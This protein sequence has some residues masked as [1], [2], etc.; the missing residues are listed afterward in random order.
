MKKVCRK[1]QPFPVSRPKSTTQGQGSSHIRAGAYRI[2]GGWV[3]FDGFD[4][5]TLGGQWQR[6]RTYVP[7]VAIWRI[8]YTTIG[9][10]Y[11]SGA[12]VQGLRCYSPQSSV[13]VFDACRYVSGPASGRA[14]SDRLSFGT[15]KDVYLHRLESRNAPISSSPERRRNRST[16]KLN[17]TQSKA[18]RKWR[19]NVCSM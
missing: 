17:A 15:S 18:F 1:R 16:T 10:S 2:S 5:G 12:D 13:T 3:Q 14:P 9:R 19:R 8:S 6:V 7:A 11:V 4:G